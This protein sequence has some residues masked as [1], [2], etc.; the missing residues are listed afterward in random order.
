MT[1]RIDLTRYLS[2][3]TWIA[4]GQVLKF[5]DVE[6]KVLAVPGHSPGSTG[7]YSATENCVFVG[8]TLFAGSI[9]NTDLPGGNFRTLMK[10]IFA[11]LLTLPDG[12]LVFPGH[13]PPT[14]IKQERESNPFVQSL[15]Q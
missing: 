4:D 3:F 11:K 10:S 5:G 7:I 14:T 15:V 6:F 1:K 2:K 9:G 12:T 13:G 8:D